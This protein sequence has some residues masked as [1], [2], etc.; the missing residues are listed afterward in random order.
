VPLSSR[1]PGYLIG[2]FLLVLVLSAPQWMTC[3]EVA[4]QCYR[5]RRWPQLPNLEDWSRCIER[6]PLGAAAPDWHGRYLQVDSGE[7]VRNTY[8]WRVTALDPRTRQLSLIGGKITG[9]NDMCPIVFGDRLWLVSSGEAYEFVDGVPQPTNFV[10]PILK[11][12]P[13]EHFL[14]GENPAYFQ[15][16]RNGIEVSSFTEGAWTTT[17]ELILPDR[18]EWS[19]TDDPF[20]VDHLWM[21]R[22][23]VHDGQTHLFMTANRSLMYRKGLEL[24][25]LTDEP[26]SALR[27]SNHDPEI[28]PWTRVCVL[29]RES[30]EIEGNWVCGMLLDGQPIALTIEVHH[31]GRSIG[32]LYRL[33]GTKWTPFASQAFPLGSTWFRT[34]NGGDGK[35]GLLI[36]NTS[37]RSYVYDVDES[38]F[39]LIPWKYATG[40]TSLKLYPTL[41]Q[42]GAVL[43]VTSILSMLL[44]V[45]VWLLMDHYTRPDYSFRDQAVS[46]ASVGRRGLARVL[47]FGLVVSSTIGLGWFLLRDLDWI[48]LAEV[49]NSGADHPMKQLVVRAVWLLMMWLCT[50]GTVLVMAQGRWGITPGKWC[51]G[52]RTVQSSLRPCG[53]AKSLV[54]EVVLWGDACGFLCWAPGLLSIALT[55]K[56]QRLGDLVADTLVVD[57]SSM[58]R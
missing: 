10:R 55:N 5:W 9:G 2:L 45:G 53:F 58:K 43:V 13:H 38:G 39:R 24:K 48:L 46:L 40:I 57:A 12:G 42:Y 21:N 26:A 47:D 8:H 14:L 35:P 56:R 52:L 49:V 3:I 20:N 37:V 51:C 30:S 33:D 19:I 4:E 11:G 17:H 50:F 31:D 1:K 22:C 18:R 44:G 32:Q 54:R 41:L 29:P 7:W 6:D 36:V 16:M 34:L 25:P 28:T 23:I 15:R 27:T